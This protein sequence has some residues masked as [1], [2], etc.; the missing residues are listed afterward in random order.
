MRAAPASSSTTLT[1]PT[2]Y[3]VKTAG[4][5]IA[6]PGST[7]SR[8]PRHPGRPALV[9]DDRGQLG[10]QL[11][12]RLGVVLGGVRDAEAAAEAE[13][14][15]L[16]AVVRADLRVQA[17][18]AARGHLE[19]RG[20][21]DL[22]ADVGVQPDELERRLG[23]HPLDRAGRLATGQGEPELLV[24]VGGRDV[25]VRVR[26]DADLDADHH[27]RAD[28]AIGGELG[29]PADLVEGVDDDPADARVERAGRARRRTC[30]CR[31]A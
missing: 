2:S 18:D 3:N 17:D 24:L 7:D 14:G 25:L 11:H 31:A 21:E 13:L 9:L 1:V 5:A 6:R 27:R 8:G 10:R 20:V 15:Q 19:R 23:E 16:D 4:P 22:R 26:L 29:E 28:A 12:G 30:C